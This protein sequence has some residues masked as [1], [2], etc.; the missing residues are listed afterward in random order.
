MNE[1]QGEFYR[2]CYWLFITSVIRQFPFCCLGI[3]HNIVGKMREACFN[4]SRRSGRVSGENVSPVA[5]AVN[6]IVL[7]SH[8][9]QCS[10]NGSVAVG[11]VLHG[12]PHNICN[13][14]VASVVKLAHGMQNAPLHRLQAVIKMR[15]CT[16]E[17]NIRSVVQKPVLVHS[18]E[19]VRNGVAATVGVVAAVLPGILLIVTGC[20][21]LV[22]SLNL[23]NVSVKFVVVHNL[24]R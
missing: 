10:G 18:G 19:L 8:L 23:L 16:L 12:V 3:E 21:I 1:Q 20:E 13:L 14:V 6:E 7:L 15:H 4:V 11:V 2:Q 22:R 9:H 5:L 17:N 24:R